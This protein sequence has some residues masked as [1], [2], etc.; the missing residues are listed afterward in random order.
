MRIV[1]ILTALIMLAGAV[2]EAQSSI[3]KAADDARK[4]KEAAR[5]RDGQVSRELV[6]ARQRKYVNIKELTVAGA[7]SPPKDFIVQLS[8]KWCAP[9]HLQKSWAED[10]LHNFPKVSYFVIDIESPEAPEVL[11]RL[12]IRHSDHEGIPVT[13]RF[14]EGSAVDYQHGFDAAALLKILSAA[15][16]S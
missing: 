15:G 1:R 16:K 5:D 2:A 13:Y 9:C 12:N 3:V 14:R 11:K 10:Q 8:A 6:A 4:K 7:K